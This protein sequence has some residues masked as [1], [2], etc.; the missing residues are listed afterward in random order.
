MT[1]RDGNFFAIK[2]LTKTKPIAY[3]RFKDEVTVMA[4]CGVSGVVPII[5]QN[6]PANC[7]TERAWYVMPLG[8]PAVQFLREARFRAIVEQVAAVAEVL[9]QLHAKEIFH[10][11]IKPENLI[12]IDGQTAIG[13]F[14]LV[15]YP[16]KASYTGVKER[17]GPKWTMAPEVS[18]S[19]T[20]AQ[21]GPADVFALAKTLW[22]LLTKI[23][24]GFD[25]PYSSVEGV[26][27]EKYADGAFIAPLEKLLA[28][29]TALD[30]AMRPSM[31]DFTAGLLDWLKMEENFHSRNPLE[32]ADVQ[33]RIFPKFVPSRAIWSEMGD[34]VA[35]L[36]ELGARSDMNHMFLASGGGL[37]LTGA[38]LARR[39]TG[40]IELL[41]GGLVSLLKPQRLLFESFGSD[42]QWNY[43]RLE[44]DTLAPSDVYE[45][46]EKVGYE[47]LTEIGGEF[48]A[49]RGYWDEGYYR[50]EKLPENSR[51][52]MRYFRGS[53]VIFQ[54]SS[55]Y[56]KIG[57]TYDRRHDKMTA[58]EFRKYI[59]DTVQQLAARQ[60]AASAVAAPTSTPS[61][62]AR[63]PGS[64]AKR[65]SSISAMLREL[66]EAEGADD[67]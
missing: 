51:V 46:A 57:A 15:D 58:D 37:D 62:A 40:C 38:Q 36:N 44:A 9:R 30:P 13:D 1:S 31:E 27:L 21:P 10:R 2:L 4:G 55:I 14:G 18:R 11:D 60:A 52:V 17:L 50:D 59:S 65:L 7:A 26:S 43:F 56:N 32:W 33:A 29:A 63:P 49:D 19:G 67:R 20:K 61:P 8:T 12:T 3:G 64:A 45:G 5:D 22:I 24:Q 34:I 25:G 41:F 6:L 28:A 48:Y 54:K 53:F 47:E 35:V 39:E 23:P 42:L 66:H 16:A